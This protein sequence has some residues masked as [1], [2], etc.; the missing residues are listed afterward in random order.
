[1]WIRSEPHLF[2]TVD[3][4]LEVYNQGKFRVWTWKV[5]TWW[6]LILKGSEDVLKK[7]V[8]LFTWIRIR[9]QSIRSH[10]R[11]IFQPLLSI[12]NF[13]P[14]KNL[15]FS[16]FF[17]CFLLSACFLIS[18]CFFFFLSSSSCSFLRF[19]FSPGCQ[20]TIMRVFKTAFQN[21]ENNSLTQ[22]KLW[23]YC[24]SKKSWLTIY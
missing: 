19:S 12:K 1:M 16:D 24:M 4:D 21:K 23:A 7:L 13:R 2:G 14:L 9:I 8:I 10:L 5:W 11:F 15:T 3:P 17:F 6:E 22:I 20:L 18:V